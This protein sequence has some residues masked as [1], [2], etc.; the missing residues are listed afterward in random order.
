MAELTPEQ[1]KLLKEYHRASIA[2]DASTWTDNDGKDG[3][4]YWAALDA[5]IDVGVDPFHHPAP[6]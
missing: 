3:I 2:W 1:Q 6:Q 5:C 4:A